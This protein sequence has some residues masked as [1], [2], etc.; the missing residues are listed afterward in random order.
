[1]RYKVSHTTTY[2][3]SE[4][5]PVCHNEVHLIPRDDERQHCVSNRLTIKP[6]PTT[7]SRHVDYFGNFVSYFTIQEGH[8][9]LVVTA[10][11]KVEVAPP[12]PVD[13]SRTPPWESVRAAL[14]TD[15]QPTNLAAYQF[16]FD[17]PYVRVSPAVAEFAAA[18]FLPGRP[19]LEAALELNDR[20]NREFAYD[21]TATQIN[22]PLEEVLRNRKGVCQDFAHLEIA[23]L[24]SLGLA[25]RYVS[26][27][28]LTNPPPGQPRLLG[29]DASHAWLAVYCPG[30]GW[31][32]L[33]PTNNQIPS[34]K[35][36]TLAWGRDYS[37]VCPIKGVF[38]GGGQH[39]MNVSVDVAP[40]G[41]TD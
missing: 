2:S 29:S 3:Y 39:G 23:C 8:H 1:M 13:A 15:R 18:S 16:V 9:K 24:R 7:I 5:V 36:I 41:P 19:L 27:Y 38:V 34:T 32:D 37:D 40:L 33:D 10:T 22:T 35:H 26:G 31:F 21:R 14:A 12:L 6:E 11:S 30:L 20:I 4:T 17:S 28:L 25:S